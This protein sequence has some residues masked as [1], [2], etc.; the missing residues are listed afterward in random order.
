MPRAVNEI[1]SRIAAPEAAQTYLLVGLPSLAFNKVPP[2][3]GALLLQ[4]TLP[5][6]GPF[7]VPA[8]QTPI[9]VEVP[10]LPGLIGASIAMQSIQIPI[11]AS[12]PGS[13]SS[14][15]EVTIQ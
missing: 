9:G 10:L 1:L 11:S 2:L 5:P 14:E 6:I 7:P 3:Q 15:I 8:G 13:F 4:L 12:N